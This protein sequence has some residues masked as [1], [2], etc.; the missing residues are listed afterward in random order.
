VLA[1]EAATLDLLS[2][3]RLEL[4]LGAGWMTTDYQAAGIPMDPASK[5]VERLAAAVK[6]IKALFGSG[7]VDAVGKHYSVRGLDG[8]PM[9]VQ[10]PHPP[11]TIGGGGRR[12]LSLAAQEAETVGLNIDL[13]H[14]RIDATAGPTATA[15]ATEQ[16]LQWIKEAAGERFA[17]L[18]LQTRIHLAAVTDNRWGLAE[19]VG[20]ALGLTPEQA[21]ES[22]HGLAGTVDEIVQQCLDRRA[23]W[24]ISYIT[25]P[26]ESITEMTPVVAELRGR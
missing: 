24:G 9:P 3:G 13:R 14:G 15:A 2:D 17:T 5:R 18:E 16:K 21:I 19:A 1:K 7:S 25:I 20:P 10:V 26:A 6:M 12:I 23:R 22:P 11:I 4:G 8:T